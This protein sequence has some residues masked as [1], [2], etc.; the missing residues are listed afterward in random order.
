MYAITNGSSVFVRVAQII[1]VAETL[2]HVQIVPVRLP[3]CEMRFTI[4]KRISTSTFPFRLDLLVPG[5]FGDTGMTRNNAPFLGIPAGYVKYEGA[6]VLSNRTVDAPHVMDVESEFLFSTH[7][8][9]MLGGIVDG[10][11]YTDA[12]MSTESENS[13]V[14]ASKFGWNN[15]V[16]LNGADYSGFIT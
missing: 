11:V 5:G 4:K 3:G 9:F 7:G 1:Q 14:L 8:H 13:Y 10:W 2:W 12:D 15:A 6:T 16:V